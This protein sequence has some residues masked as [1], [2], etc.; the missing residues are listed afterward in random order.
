MIGGI[1]PSWYCDNF[2]HEQCIYTNVGADEIPQK[3]IYQ[4][5]TK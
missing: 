2:N 5:H 4:A 1:M 3:F